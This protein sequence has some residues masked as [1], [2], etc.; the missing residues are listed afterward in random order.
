MGDMNG[1]SNVASHLHDLPNAELLTCF[2]STY[3][4]K[5]SWKLWTPTPNILSAITSSL[6]GGGPAVGGPLSLGALTF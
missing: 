5:A 2:Y 6:Q 1:M 4:Q 3:P